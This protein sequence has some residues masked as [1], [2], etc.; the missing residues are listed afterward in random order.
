MTISREVVI[1]NG[2]PVWRI[3]KNDVCVECA[4]GTKAAGVLDAIE[5]TLGHGFSRH[6]SLGKPE[7][8]PDMTP[9]PGV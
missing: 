2:E 1:R 8:G 9:D 7:R 3:C 5:A 6:K 4:S